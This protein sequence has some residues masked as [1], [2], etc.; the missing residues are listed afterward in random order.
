MFS[1][2]FFPNLTIKINIIPIIYIIDFS[3]TFRDSIS[4]TSSKLPKIIESFNYCDTSF[5][6]EILNTNEDIEVKSE[7]AMVIDQMMTNVIDVVE[8][9]L[10]PVISRHIKFIH[11]LKS[12]KLGDICSAIAQLCH[13]NTSLAEKMWVVLFPA[14]WELLSSTQKAVN[15]LNCFNAIIPLITC[16]LNRSLY[17]YCFRY[18]Y[19]KSIN[20]L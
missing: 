13:M 4:S 17:I 12:I 7:Y 16:I 9:K 5:I 8:G 18:Y 3:V 10:G 15:T 20:L 6:Q 2:L 11:N 14:I 19:L 1:Y